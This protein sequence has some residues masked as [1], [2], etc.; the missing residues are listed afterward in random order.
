VGFLR[1]AIDHEFF[2]ELWDVRTHL[3]EPDQLGPSA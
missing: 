3:R 1:K 2:P